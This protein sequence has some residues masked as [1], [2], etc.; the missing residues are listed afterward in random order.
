MTLF[1]TIALVRRILAKPWVQKILGFV[2]G[3][4]DKA[5]GVD[6]EK[7]KPGRHD[8]GAKKTTLDDIHNPPYH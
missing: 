8:P 6:G 4:L 1:E 2:K 7:P 5:E 3:I